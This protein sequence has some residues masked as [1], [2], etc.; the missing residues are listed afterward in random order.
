[1]ADKTL[2]IK[3]ATD[4]QLD[5]LLTRLRKES[6]LQSLIVDIKRRT[7]SEEFSSN[8]SASLPGV[9]TEEPIDTLYHKI[10]KDLSHHGI[11]GMRW[12]V[13][14]DRGA[15]GRVDSPD[16]AIVRRLARSRPEDLSNA[17]LKELNTRMQLEGTFAT[18]QRGRVSAGRRI[19][20]E[21]LVNSGKNI[22][23][24]FVTKQGEEILSRILTKAVAGKP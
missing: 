5:L 15:D 11:L 14:R 16:A 13:R 20:S 1:M 9:S 7:S 6:E 22:A 8:P 21:I 18:L 24:N 19:V 4:K 3:G 10:E 23:T 12:G 17:E 2:T